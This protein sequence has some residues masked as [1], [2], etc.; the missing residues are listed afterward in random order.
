VVAELHRYDRRTGTF[1][2]EFRVQ[3]STVRQP[4]SGD[5]WT[6][7]PLMMFDGKNAT[8]WCDGTDEFGVAEFIRLEYPE[9]TDFTTIQILPG[10]GQNARTFMSYNQVKTFTVESASPKKF[11]Y[12]FPESI[13]EM[14]TIE[15]LRPIKTDWARIWIREIFSARN[16]SVCISE[17]VLE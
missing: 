14:Q 12:T 15:L 2:L 8:A 5:D 16:D 3:V 1:D 9:A 7:G 6:H 17:F 11:G 13:R 4:K 10:W